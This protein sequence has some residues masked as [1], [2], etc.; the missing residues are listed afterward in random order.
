M[1]APVC[2]ARRPVRLRW[3][4]GEPIMKAPPCTN[5]TAPSDPALDLERTISVGTPPRLVCEKRTPNGT[6]SVRVAML[7]QCR[8]TGIG[9]LGCS[10]GLRQLL[11]VNRASVAG[12]DSRMTFSSSS[13]LKL[14]G[15]ATA[16]G[17][18]GSELHGNCLPHVITALRYSA[19]YERAVVDSIETARQTT[20]GKCEA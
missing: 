13:Q 19:G 4:T 11:T 10:A 9:K 2:L 17:R 20:V 18:R 15:G 7:A 3:L 6:L 1:V 16:S 14:W 5:S 12:M 8:C